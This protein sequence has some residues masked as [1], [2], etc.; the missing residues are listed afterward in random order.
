MERRRRPPR[1]HSNREE[2]S[3][4]VETPDDA[5]ETFSTWQPPPERKRRF[6]LSIGAIIGIIVAL[7]IGGSA[8]VNYL[9]RQEDAD[10]IRD[11]NAAAQQSGNSRSQ[12]ET[13]RISVFDVRDGDCFNT[14]SPITGS[15]VQYFEDVTLTPCVGFWDYRVLSS[16]ASSLTG[17][18]PSDVAFAQEAARRCPRT[19]DF[20]FYPSED[21]WAEG[22]RSVVCLDE[23]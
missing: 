12:L 9:D 8:L 11:A 19:H 23:G 4:P 6:P 22:D 7:V 13:G 10:R 21:T 2:Y 14:N 17:G 18:Y 3:P 5:T 20:F 16:Y 15:A 1:S